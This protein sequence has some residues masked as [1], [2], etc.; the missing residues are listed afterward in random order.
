MPV[1]CRF[2]GDLLGYAFD[3]MGQPAIESKVILLHEEND[4]AALRELR[5][6]KE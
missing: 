3:F 2:C 6:C 5:R 1:N 4:C